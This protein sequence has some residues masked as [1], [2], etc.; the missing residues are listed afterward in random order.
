MCYLRFIIIYLPLSTIKLA[1]LWKMA[2]SLK[3]THTNTYLWF[4]IVHP[5][6]YFHINLV[7]SFSIFFPS[8]C[9]LHSSCCHSLYIFIWIVSLWSYNILSLSVYVSVC[10]PLSHT[11]IYSH[12]H[13]TISIHIFNMLFCVFPLKTV[14][15]ISICLR[16][17][18]F[19]GKKKFPHLQIY[20]SL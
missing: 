11:C 6:A 12:T 4:Y 3:I 18:L 10:L 13:R 20:N 9:Y 1:S 2:D 5:C 17:L 19:S 14:I 7:K 16:I 8:A 15:I